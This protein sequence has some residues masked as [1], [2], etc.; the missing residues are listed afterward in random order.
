MVGR[1]ELPAEGG[2]GASAGVVGRDELPAEGVEAIERRL[3]LL[4]RDGQRQHD[5]KPVWLAG[6][7]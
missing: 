1:D 5:A 6:S 7:G 3:R 4:A 2:P